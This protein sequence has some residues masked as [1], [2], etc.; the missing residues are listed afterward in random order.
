MSSFLQYYGAFLDWDVYDYHV[1][2]QFLDDICDPFDLTGQVA[3]RGHSSGD[4]DLSGVVDIG[5]LTYLIAFLFN[6]GAAPPFSPTAD[7]DKDGQIT[8]ADLTAL[9]HLLFFE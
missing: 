5:D 7:L 8:V 9:V 1:T 6:G 2:G 4:V 3:L